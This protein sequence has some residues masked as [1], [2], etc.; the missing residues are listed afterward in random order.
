MPLLRLTSSIKYI[1]F[2]WYAEPDL[3]VGLAWW[4]RDL[5]GGCYFLALCF[6]AYWGKVMFDLNM[7]NAMTM[8]YHTVGFSLLTL[9]H[10]FYISLLK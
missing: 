6:M 5:F 3:E 7:F 2:K 1:P 9:K 4:C 8:H 10:T